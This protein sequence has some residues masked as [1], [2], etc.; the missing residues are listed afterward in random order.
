MSEGKSESEVSANSSVNDFPLKFVFNLGSERRQLPNSIAM[1]P[2]TVS[3]LRKHI[4][5]HVTLFTNGDFEI[6]GNSALM[7]V[8]LS[9]SWGGN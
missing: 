5:G 7:V 3:V 6:S 2:I 8:G 4:A 1:L 9:D